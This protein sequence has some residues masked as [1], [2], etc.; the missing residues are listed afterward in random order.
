M[1]SSNLSSAYAC[2]P[3]GVSSSSKHTEK[4]LISELLRRVYD[5]ILPDT[6]KLAFVSSFI[7]AIIFKSYM[8]FFQLV[9]ISPL[10]YFLHYCLSRPSLPGVVGWSPLM[11]LGSVFTGLEKYFPLRE[12]IFELLSCLEFE[13][14]RET[15]SGLDLL[16]IE[17]DFGLLVVL[18]FAYLESKLSRTIFFEFLWVTLFLL[19]CCK[20]LSG[21]FNAEALGQ[22]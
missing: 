15:L 14:K 12:M 10:P 17:I 21:L 18:S 2:Y 9:F 13:P 1:S 22:P 11:L 3:T 19:L 5:N 6:S 8:L 4:S 7:S 20:G 16:V